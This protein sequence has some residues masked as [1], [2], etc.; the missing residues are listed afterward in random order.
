MKDTNNKIT[1]YIKGDSDAFLTT[2]S[3]AYEITFTMPDG[4][5]YTSEFPFDDYGSKSKALNAAKYELASYGYTKARK[6]DQPK[7]EEETPKDTLISRKLVDYNLIVLR[8][9]LGYLIDFMR[10]PEDI[11]EAMNNLH[12]IVEEHFTNTDG[13]NCDIE[14]RYYE[15]IHRD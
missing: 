12:D 15:E 6:Q 10:Y 5:K 7:Q 11:T 4:I 8:E 2:K 13:L 14:L 9:T 1:R 3:N